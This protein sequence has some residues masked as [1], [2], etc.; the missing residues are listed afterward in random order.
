MPR[1]PNKRGILPGFGLSM[2]ITLL[3]L[4]L[5]VL[6]PLSTVVLKT[7]SVGWA[8]FWHT[9]STDRALAS[10]RITFGASFVAALLN[11]GFGLVVA[12][13]LVR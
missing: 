13:A 7:S 6:I 10:Y 5:V 11:V 8:K 4:S 1:R 9:V 12:W 3:F 2:G